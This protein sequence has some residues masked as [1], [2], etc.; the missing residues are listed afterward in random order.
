MQEGNNTEPERRNT[1]TRSAARA[2][3]AA[4]DAGPQIGDELDGAPALSGQ[5]CNVF[6]CSCSPPSL[7]YCLE[8][9]AQLWALVGMA[10]AKL[11]R[12]PGRM[13]YGTALHMLCQIVLHISCL[14]CKMGCAAGPAGIQQQVSVQLSDRLF[15]PHLGWSMLP[16]SFWPVDRTA[17]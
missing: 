13:H 9:T 10:N 2:D 17:Q 11:I 1:R 6:W 16:A 5:Q 4:M 8:P 12:A 7:G 3:Y 14:Q 15:L